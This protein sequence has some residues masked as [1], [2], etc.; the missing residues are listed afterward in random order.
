MAMPVSPSSKQEPEDDALARYLAQPSRRRLGQVVRAC[1]EHVWFVALRLTG[2]TEDAADL[3]QDLFLGLLLRPPPPD[4]VRS[5]R[6]YLTFRVLTLARRLGRARARRREREL[7]AARSIHARDEPQP[8]ALAET[9]AALASLPPPLRDPIEL[10][11]L[12]G[13]K[14]AE[15][16]QRLGL[17][18]RAVEERLRRGRAAIQKRVGAAGR[19]ESAL[20][21]LFFRS[22]ESTVRPG[23]LDDLMAGVRHGHVLQFPVTSIVGVTMAKKLAIPAVVLFLLSIAVPL[24]FHSRRDIAPP[25]A[26]VEAE[27]VAAGE[28]GSGEPSAGREALTGPWA[29]VRNPRTPRHPGG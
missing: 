7:R 4:Q 16:A 14:N 1:H 9:L 3:C 20:A 27:R 11:Y 19:G 21:A 28:R 10:R 29:G 13:M 5:A 15:I 26:A 24:L 12:A 8:Q 17:S 6:G 22:G 25:E 2:N 18:E 23:L